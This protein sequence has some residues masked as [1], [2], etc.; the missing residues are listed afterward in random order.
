[1]RDLRLFGPAAVLAAGCLLLFGVQLQRPIRLERPL[2]AMP[3][4]VAGYNGVD[5][6]MARGLKPRDGLRRH[7]HVDQ[8][9][10][11]V[12]SIVSSSARLAA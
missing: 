10:Q 9:L 12:R 7:R 11:P 5:R 1:M 3:L 6:V 8:E 4:V 2:R